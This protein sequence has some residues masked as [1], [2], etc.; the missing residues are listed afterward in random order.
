MPSRTSTWTAAPAFAGLRAKARRPDH[1]LRVGGH[2]A[3]QLR[4]RHGAE[5]QDRRRE[6]GRPQLLRLGHGGHAQPVAPACSA[7]LATGTAP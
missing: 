5:H 4:A 2:G 6:P 1:D 3:A 7:A